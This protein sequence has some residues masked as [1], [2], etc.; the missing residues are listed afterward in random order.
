MAF[1]LLSYLCHRH[2][3]FLRKILKRKMFRYYR[4]IFFCL[5]YESIELYQHVDR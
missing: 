3:I 4:N 5:S 2:T 1:N